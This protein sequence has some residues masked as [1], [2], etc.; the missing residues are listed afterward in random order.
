MFTAMESTKPRDPGLEAARVAAGSYRKLARH[1]G[2]TPQA[3]S[4]WK[5]IPQAHLEEI[6]ELTGLHASVLRPDLVGLARLIS[7]QKADKAVTCS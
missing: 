5:R 1:I 3:I 7:E 4:R 2:L 6:A